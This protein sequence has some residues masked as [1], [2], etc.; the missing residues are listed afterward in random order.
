MDAIL[1][2][3]PASTPPIVLDACAG[4]LATL[5][6]EREEREESDSD[7]AKA[8]FPYVNAK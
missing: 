7:S 3:R 5:P 8:P 1:G 2:H 6:A 4:G